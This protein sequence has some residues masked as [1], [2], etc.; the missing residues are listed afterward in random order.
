MKTCKHC[1]EKFKPVKFNQKYCFKNECVKAWVKDLKAKEWAKKKKKLKNDLKTLNDY[2]KEAQKWV[3]LYVRNRDKDKK[4]I[5][6]DKPLSGKF[7]AGHYYSV[8]SSSFL[9]YNLDNIFGQCTPCN[10]FLSGNL[11]EYRKNLIKRIG[12]EKLEYL[13][14][15]CKNEKRYTKEELKQIAKKYKDLSKK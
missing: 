5:S 8:N 9:R 4:C 1:K 12:P 14:S 13:D 2:K 3:N 11:I 7:D 15:V 6:C 10:R